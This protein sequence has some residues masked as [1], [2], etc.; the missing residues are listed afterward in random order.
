M[1]SKHGETTPAPTGITSSTPSPGPLHRG[2]DTTRHTGRSGPQSA[3]TRRNMR[4]DGTGDCPGPRKETATRRKATQG[5]GVCSQV[6]VVRACVRVSVG[7]LQPPP[8]RSFPM[9]PREGLTHFTCCAIRRP[10]QY[11]S[12]KTVSQPRAGGP[13]ARSVTPN[14]TSRATDNN[15]PLPFC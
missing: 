13:A 1:G 2:N 5:G 11:T 4:R 3:A 14:G 15:R 9:Q 7:G 12:R 6:C 10:Q 8:P